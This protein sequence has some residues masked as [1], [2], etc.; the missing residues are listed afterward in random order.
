MDFIN[1]RQ[2]M[3]ANLSLNIIMFCI[4]LRHVVVVVLQYIL[5]IYSQVF[6]I[7]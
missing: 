7:P 1:P 2:Q 3:Q 6:P 4:K 5:C